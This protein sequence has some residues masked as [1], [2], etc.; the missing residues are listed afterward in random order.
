MLR[1][2]VG[3]RPI[4]RL[5]Y[6][7]SVY[8]SG[9]LQYC[10]RYVGVALPRSQEPQPCNVHW[11]SATRLKLKIQILRSNAGRGVEAVGIEMRYH[12]LETFV[13]I[14]TCDELAMSV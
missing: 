1:T 6:D 11:S 8:R 4:K 3:I 10:R 12:Q 13:A 5:A 7:S 14:Y 2:A 9:S